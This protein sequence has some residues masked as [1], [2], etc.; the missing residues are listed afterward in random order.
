MLSS[1]SVLCS[2]LLSCQCAA[3]GKLHNSCSHMVWRVDQSP[4][5]CIFHSIP[6][7]SFHSSRKLVQIEIN[8]TSYSNTSTCIIYN[9]LIHFNLFFVIVIFWI[10][11]IKTTFKKLLGWSL[12]SGH[13]PSLSSVVNPHLCLIRTRFFGCPFIPH[14]MHSDRC[15]S[16]HCTYKKFV[17]AVRRSLY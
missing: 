8:S 11:L 14:L 4:S 15:S 12:W 6:H 7:F 5:F 17:C 9:S 10:L 2:L 3:C 13:S 1:A 16:A